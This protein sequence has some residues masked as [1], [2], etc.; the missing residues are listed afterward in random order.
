MKVHFLALGVAVLLAIAPAGWAAD[1]KSGDRKA[2]LGKELNKEEGAWDVIEETYYSVYFDAA[3]QCKTLEK[4]QKQACLKDARTK[5][6]KA[7][8]GK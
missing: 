1:T 2:A 3:A 8:R 4:P 5:A 6:A 7:A